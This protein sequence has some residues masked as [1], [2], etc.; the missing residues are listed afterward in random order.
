[1]V[2][3]H[4]VEYNPNIQCPFPVVEEKRLHHAALG[5]WL[6]LLVVLSL[7]QVSLLDILPLSLPAP[8]ARIWGPISRVRTPRLMLSQILSDEV[9]KALLPQSASCHVCNPRRV[10]GNV[11]LHAE[12][13]AENGEQHSGVAA[14]DRAAADGQWCAVGGF[15]QRET[16]L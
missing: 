5:S 10:W 15:A 12:G 9:S 8:L 4:A 2:F 11:Q 7:L 3:L 14:E 6:A 16:C 1:M 13:G